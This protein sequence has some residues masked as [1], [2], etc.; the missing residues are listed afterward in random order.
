MKKLAFIIFLLLQLS[1]SKKQEPEFSGTISFKVDGQLKALQIDKSLNF[2]MGLA[3]FIFI[4]ADR[5]LLSLSVQKSGNINTNTNTIFPF[6]S[7]DGDNATANLIINKKEEYVFNSFIFSKP[8]TPVMP[9][10]NVVITKWTL[11]EIEGTFDFTAIGQKN[12]N[13]KL[14][15]TEG[16]FS[17]KR[18]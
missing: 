9:Q 15:I 7:C 18:N 14:S 6:C 12:E 11:S 1:C 2:T 4:N 5:E 13:L 8:N 17:V 3:D 10:G 16:K